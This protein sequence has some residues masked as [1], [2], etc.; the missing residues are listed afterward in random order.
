MYEHLPHLSSTNS[1]NQLAFGR[2]KKPPPI[3]DMSYYVTS[4]NS[5]LNINN[6]HLKVSG[7]IQTDVMKLGAIEF[8]PPASDV[9]GTVNFTNVTT[10]VTTSSNLNVGGTLML[11]TVEVVATTH[12][13]EN[14]TALGNVT[15]NTVQFTNATTSLVA[16]GNVEVGGELTVSGFVGTS[17][18]GAIVVPSGTTGE[19]PTGVVG[20]IRYN[21]TTSKVEYHTGTTWIGIGQFSATGG[22]LDVTSAVYK[23]HKFESSGT[24]QAYSAG[25]VDILVVGGG[26]AGGGGRHAGGGGAGAVIHA[27]SVNITPG[28]YIITIGAGGSGAG[29][30][31]VPGNATNTTIV[32]D[33]I[34]LYSALR[35]GHGGVHPSPGS[36]GSYL[37]TGQDGGC[38]GGAGH[39]TTQ[40]NSGY[41]RL[42]LGLSATPAFGGNGGAGLNRSATGAGGGAGANGGTGTG[43][44]SALTG[45]GGDGGIGYQSDITGTSLY[46]SGGGGGSGSPY[47]Q[48]NSSSCT[49]RGGDG[50]NGGGGGGAAGVTTSASG[51]RGGN[52]GA[53]Y[54]AGSVGVKTTVANA[55]HGG[56]GGNNTGGGGGGAGGWS[57]DGNGN[58]GTVEKGLWSYVI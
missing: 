55:C 9:P 58:G 51:A 53:G 39:S 32:K 49:W 34:T 36:T 29:G 13:L 1:R 26:G 44:E 42:G 33:G 24:F 14:T 31:T 27:T 21:T 54:N 46:W 18:T 23:I 20:M 40:T 52:G 12:T 30:N 11:G 22:I 45:N 8:A 19:Q 37:E 56:A 3:I 47:D 10:G 43:A 4:E 50:G 48:R 38:G 17:G 15:S 41:A 16:S 35:G 7:N 2:L 5:V 6:A 25:T 28:S 57:N